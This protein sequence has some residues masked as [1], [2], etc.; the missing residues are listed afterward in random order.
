MSIYDEVFAVKRTNAGGLASRNL[1]KGKPMSLE[2]SMAASQGKSRVS[3]DARHLAFTR[4]CSTV[5][6]PPQ[7]TGRPTADEVAGKLPDTREGVEGR[8]SIRLI[9]RSIYGQIWHL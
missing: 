2:R 5:C 8:P 6:I 9:L 7:L 1:Q 3:K 4:T